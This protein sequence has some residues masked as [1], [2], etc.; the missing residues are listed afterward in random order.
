MRYQVQKC[1]VE[2]ISRNPILGYGVGYEKKLLTAYCLEVR[3]F[4]NKQLVSY[5]SHNVY[6]S[7]MFSGGLLAL[8]PFI[9]MLL[10]NIVIGIKRRDLIHVSFLTIFILAF[11]TENYLVRLNGILL[12][13]FLNTYFYLKNYRKPEKK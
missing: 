1:S 11:L 2:L 6:L 7:I 10:N 4:R 9:F 8:I 13:T 12:F 5:T 3:N